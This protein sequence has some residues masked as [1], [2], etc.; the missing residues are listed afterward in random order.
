MLKKSVKALKEF[1]P[2]VIQGCDFSFSNWKSPPKFS[3]V[4]CSVKQFSGFHLRE[5]LA[6]KALH[7]NYYS[8]LS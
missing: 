7:I 3:G 2:Q 5:L 1:R 4:K 8:V 6:L